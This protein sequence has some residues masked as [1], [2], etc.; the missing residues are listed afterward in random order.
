MPF[1]G[2]VPVPRKP[3][4]VVWPVAR[5]PFQPAFA[6]VSSWPDVV[7]SVDQACVSAPPVDRVSAVLHVVIALSAVTSTE[8][9]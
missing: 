6:K 8:A 7:T 1:P 5:L 4:A 2:G 3:N 9:W